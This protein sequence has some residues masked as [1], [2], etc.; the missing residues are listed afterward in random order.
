MM[1]LVLGSSAVALTSPAPAPS[2]AAESQPSVCGKYL[3]I[4]PDPAAD[5][6]DQRAALVN[7]W[8][9]VS[10]QALTGS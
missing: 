8:N 7:L 10:H 6:P 2:L 3:D 9:A 4:R 5:I 1:L